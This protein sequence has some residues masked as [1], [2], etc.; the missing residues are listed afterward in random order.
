[1]QELAA[2]SAD[3]LDLL[4]YL[5]A[6]HHGKVRLSLRSSPD[7]ERVDVPDPCRGGRRQARGVRD[8][9]ALKSCLIPA[10][11]LNALAVRLGKAFGGPAVSVAPA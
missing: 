6:S 5:V 10:A 8:G 3:E 7:D 11:D 1:M 2:L 4:V 9:D